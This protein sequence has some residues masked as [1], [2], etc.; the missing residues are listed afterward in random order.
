MR[1]VDTWLALRVSRRAVARFELAPFGANSIC[2]LRPQSTAGPSAALDP[3]PKSHMPSPSSAATRAAS[4]CVLAL[5]A[6]LLPAQTPTF[7]PADHLPTATFA[8]AMAF[9]STRERLVLI[10]G[11]PFHS[12]GQALESVWERADGAWLRGVDAPASRYGHALAYDVVRQRLVV[13]GGFDASDRPTGETWEYDGSGWRRRYPLVNPA[14]R[15]YHGMTFDSRRGRIVLFGGQNGKGLLDDLWEWDG[16]TWILANIGGGPRAR[17]GVGM[18]FDPQR[19][20]CYVFG[21][22]TPTP[23]DELWD[24][25]G[26]RW[27]LHQPA[28]RPS[29]RELAGVAFDEARDRLVVFGG[30]TYSTT[31]SPIM[32]EFDGTA[33]TSIPVP[34]IV[35]GRTAPAMAYD[36]NQRRIVMIGGASTSDDNRIWSWDGIQWTA[37][38]GRSRP[39]GPL[40]AQAT[41]TDPVRRTV[42]A[43]LFDNQARRMVHSQWDG[44][45]W[46]ERAISLP[47]ARTDHALAYDAAR[48][49]IVLFGGQSGADL[50]DTWEFDGTQWT[51]LAPAASPPPRFSHAMTYDAARQRV[52]LHGG[53]DSSRQTFADTWEFDGLTWLR[54]NPA[55]APLARLKHAMAYDPARRTVVLTGGLATYFSA[56]A[57]KDA[58][59]WNGQ[60]WTR[61]PDMYEARANHAMATWPNNGVLVAGGAGEHSLETLTATGWLSSQERRTRFTVLLALDPTRNSPLLFGYSSRGYQDQFAHG[62]FHFGG[63]GSIVFGAGGCSSTSL[64]LFVDPPY[65]GAPFNMW[66]WDRPPVQQPR[67]RAAVAWMLG[68]PA[69]IQIGPCWLGVDPGRAAVVADATNND[70]YASLVLTVPAVP[71]LR[72]ARLAAQAAIADAASPIGVT[73]SIGSELRIGG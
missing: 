4:F 17:R 45:A 63:R 39:A 66:I 24:W 16:T 29:A 31:P 52:V 14:A 27:M 59:E 18:V 62:T 33:W 67:R 26:T 44:S 70:A 73:L 1:E 37:A 10:G 72:G 30:E 11:Q 5:S 13:F 12:P 21:G 71:A 42:V 50:N 53:A 64:G 34:L 43:L 7:L 55:T 23:S 20:R 68:L 54:R 69:N 46:L 35:P 15:G 28:L 25:D 8:A 38:A 36:R 22:T 3:I 51:Q 61:L 60:T 6:A 41:V 58:W 47:S 56:L 32:W 57:M 49:R 2:A 65:L 40:N 19:G 48:D 9:D